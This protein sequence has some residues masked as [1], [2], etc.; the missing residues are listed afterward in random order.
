MA[1]LII[2]DES[3]NIGL[4]AIK[5]LRM[6][7]IARGSIIRW[8]IGDEY[9]VVPFQFGLWFTSELPTDMAIPPNEVISYL[10]GQG[11]YLIRHVQGQD[12]YVSVV[13]LA[14]AEKGKVSTLFLPWNS[15]PS[16]SPRNQ[17]TK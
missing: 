14:G 1:S 15:M 6:E 13:A 10:Y 4:P 11:S 3:P 5:N 9:A 7:I 16:E 2:G 8:E 17:V 12:E